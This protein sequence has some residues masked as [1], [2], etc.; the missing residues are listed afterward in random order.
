MADPLTAL[1]YAVQVMNFLKM[2]ITR[3]LRER[4]DSVVDPSPARSLEPYD[5][6]G[7]QSSSQ[8]CLKNIS[9]EDE[10]IEQEPKS[11]LQPNQTSHSNSEEVLSLTTGSV[12]KLNPDGVESCETSDPVDTPV[13]GAEAGE[14]EESSL[15]KSR[16]GGGQSSDLNFKKGSRKVIQASGVVEKSKEIRKLSR[17][18]SRMELIE[19]W[20]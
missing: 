12:E 9:Q 4:K 1:M 20:R 11:S 2:L 6:N 10:G 19:A 14:V 7:H 13:N 17:M 18:N 3:T 15:R 8:T 16:T 5:E